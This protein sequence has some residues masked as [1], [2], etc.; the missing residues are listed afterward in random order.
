MGV[1]GAGGINATNGSAGTMTTVSVGGIL[2]KG[3]GGTGGQYNTGSDAPGGDFLGGDGGATGGSGKGISGDNGGGGGGSIGGGFNSTVGCGGGAGANSADISGLFAVLSTAQVISTFYEDADGDTYGNPAVTF[4]GES[5]PSGYVANSLDCNDAN[6]AIHPNTFELCNGIDDNC[7]GLIDNDCGPTPSL[8]EYRSASSGNWSNASTWVRFNGTVFVTA[9][10][11]PDN[12]N[13]TITIKSGHTVII[14]SSVTTDETVVESGGTLSQVSSTLSI[15]D[16]PGE[17]IAVNGTYNFISGL[18]N[19]GG[20]MSVNGTMDWQAGTLRSTISLQTGSNSGKSTSGI[21]AIVN[22]VFINNGTFSWTDGDIQFQDAT[23]NNTGT[24]TALGNNGL[25]GVG[26]FTAFNNSGFFSK[27]IGTGTTRLA[28]GGTNTGTI[29]VTEGIIHATTDY[30]NA[31]N[32]NIDAG[33]TFS[34]NCIAGAFRL[35]TGSNF[36]GAGHFELASGELSLAPGATTATNFLFRDGTIKNVNGNPPGTLIVTGG[37]NWQKGTLSSN[38]ILDTN[39]VSTKS[40]NGIATIVSNGVLTNKGIF[41]WQDGDFNFQD[42]TLNNNVTGSF[43]ASGN[44]NF[45][46]SGGYADFNN[47]GTFTKTTGTGTTTDSI[48]GTNTGIIHVEEGVLNFKGPFINSGNINIDPG[49]TFSVNCSTPAFSLNT[50][51]NFTGG[52]N[53]QIVGGTVSVNAPAATPAT[54]TN[55][56]FSSGT[57]GNSAGTLIVT[58]GLN[59]QVG[60]LSSNLILDTNA[61]LI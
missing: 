56:L 29:N 60:N 31:G 52:G 38:L 2:I 5:A 47:A 34:T 22:G 57:I 27:S 18:L 19:G 33:K 13:G 46:F 8:G 48:G 4:T 20:T 50:G 41:N 26:G 32:I 44:N 30:A 35:N 45:L 9:P 61:V 15:A 16:G 49:K 12:T 14:N 36:T 7:D 59:W 25:L 24:I 23:F 43:T 28:V 55:I 51:S 17:D 11:P 42:A 37:L 3:N 1:G 21:A 58:G 39:A 40:T 54:A 6:A 10:T 53:F